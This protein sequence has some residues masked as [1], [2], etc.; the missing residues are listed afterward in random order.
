MTFLGK[1]IDIIESRMTLKTGLFTQEI[2]TDT[3]D[4]ILF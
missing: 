4:V 1:K 2:G 3:P